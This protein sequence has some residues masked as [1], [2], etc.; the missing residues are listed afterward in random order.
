MNNQIDAAGAGQLAE[1]LK[2]NTALTMLYL[3][4]NQ[5]ENDQIETEI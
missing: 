3:D 4:G 2:S 5:I 1:A